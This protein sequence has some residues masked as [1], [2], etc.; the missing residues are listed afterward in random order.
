[1]KL[2]LHALSLGLGLVSFISSVASTSDE[3][4]YDNEVTKVLTPTRLKQAIADVP[5]SVTIITADMISKLGIRSIP[6]ALR[7][8][9]GMAV[10]QITGNDYR[11]DYHGT[12]ILVPR[13]MNV[14]IDGVSVYGQKVARVDWKTIPVAIEDIERIEVIRGSDAATYGTNSML[15]VISII[16]KEPADVE[17]ATAKLTRGSNNVW[18][19]FARYG[20]KVGD[21][22]S[23]RVSVEHQSDDGF[24]YASTKGIGHDSTRLDMIN[25][26]SSTQITSN[27]SLDVQLSL[28]R[29]NL[30]IEN[31]DK[32]QVTFPDEDVSEYSIGATWKKNISDNHSIQFQTYAT[33]SAVSQ[34]WRSCLPEAYLLPELYA[35]GQV[36]SG[37]A[38][39]ILA[40]MVPTNVSTQDLVLVNAAIA[41]LQALGKD[42]A[43]VVCVDTNQNAVEN[44][45]DA[46]LQDIYIFS[47]KL[48]VVSGVGIRHDAVDSET[49]FGGSVSN[50]T[51]RAFTNF[52]YK[53]FLPLTV[54]AGGFLENDDLSGTSFSPR[55]AANVHLS[56]QSTV[57]FV[58]SQA[59]RKPDL[60]EQRADWSYPTSNYSIPVAGQTSG[61]Y[62]LSAIS[63]Q[64][65]VG[66]K[67]LSREIGYNGNFSR[68]GIMFDAKIFNDELSD[69][70]S[71]KLQNS[72]F[73]PT[74]DNAANLRGAELEATYAPNDEWSV[75]FG[76]SYL[77]N[78]ATSLFEQTQYAKN[79]GSL[80]ISYLAKNNWRTSFAYYGYGG[81][82]TGQ[83]Y[84]GRE[85]LVVQKDFRLNKNSQLTPSFTITHL[86]NRDSSYLVNVGQTRISSFDSAMQYTFSLKY[87]F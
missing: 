15:A 63:P 49:F 40:G 27:D 50:R 75:H 61:H 2:L 16:T 22:T 69:L 35:L 25:L 79:S 46:E 31:V 7:L 38:S 58:I 17:G 44:R 68:L 8:V 83:T 11:I 74:N 87:A 12:N 84:Y 81:D 65:L 34:P 23:Y 72:D 14:L 51:L 9:P 59:V 45:Y 41:A 47:D 36:N 53:P 4:E 86:D 71:Q 52:E 24:D 85:D 62:Y 78:N 10:T 3:S 28:V 37:Y 76:Y 6:D 30:Q 21:T 70:I 18:E 32:S 80:A 42:K 20:G 77:M 48:R 13:R 39:A 56:E 55:V 19:E 1:M 66:E 5:G 29:G 67:I 82:T 73:H 57:R 64:N 43:T 33:H 26:R 60:I 54:N